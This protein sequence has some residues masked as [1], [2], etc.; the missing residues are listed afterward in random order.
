M[1]SQTGC[2]YGLV[3][4]D[5][6]EFEDDNI[7]K[8]V[9][10]GYTPSE[11]IKAIEH[12]LD[13]PRDAI[14]EDKCNTKKRTLEEMKEDVPQ[15]AVATNTTMDDDFDIF[16]GVGR[17][18]VCNPKQDSKRRRVSF[19][20]PTM[21][22]MNK[23][24]SYFEGNN[25]DINANSKVEQ[26]AAAILKSSLTKAR[27]EKKRMNII[28]TAAGKKGKNAKKK[29]KNAH[30]LRGKLLSSGFSEYDDDDDV[31][32]MNSYNSDEEDH[33]SNKKK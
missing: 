18:Y 9:C 30:S 20:T 24:L 29:N 27:V 32:E 10:I 11:T 4:D 31:E 33:Q 19:M 26:E 21:Q 15:I 14:K 12:A 8:E 3:L 5:F 2:I 23:K 22:K 7:D 1:R 13:R 25:A 28:P 17:D 16:D 6:N